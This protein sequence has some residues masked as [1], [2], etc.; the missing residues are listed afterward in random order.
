MASNLESLFASTLHGIREMID[1]NTV[2]GDPIET[3]EGVTIIPITKVSLGFGMGGFNQE[4]KIEDQ[5]IAGGGGGGVT[6]SPVGFLVVEK[7]NIKLLNI[8]AETAVERVIDSLPEL[9]KSISSFF[10][11]SKD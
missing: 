4:E 9:I 6:V 3:N 7:G 2:I 5:Q 11:K 10:G 8:N 1:V